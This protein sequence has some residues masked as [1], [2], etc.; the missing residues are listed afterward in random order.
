ME[1]REETGYHLEDTD[2]FGLPES[3]FHPIEREEEMP[4]QF[5]EP[6][7]YVEEDDE[8]NQGWIVAA[9]IGVIALIGL[10]VYLFMFNGMDQV[11]SW[12]GKEEPVEQVVVA[13]PDPEPVIEEP[14]VEEEPLAEEP[15][16]ET[17]SLSLAPY[18]GI[19][20]ISAPTG[21]TFVVIASFVDYDLAMD[22]ARQ[23]EAQ[24]IGSKI[25]DPTRRAPL[26][27]RV[28]VSD[29]ETF[30]EGMAN[31]DTYRA[32]YGENTWILKY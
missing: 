4:P 3:D 1:N 2:D 17:P 28:A 26:I 14:V 31:I 8:P 20:R 15:I 19:E 32:E 11:S 22:Y 5:E 21:R 16:V 9:V 13:T 27:H 25:L 29:F 23:L 18:M 6:R 10:V 12:F 24:G 7:Y 30:T